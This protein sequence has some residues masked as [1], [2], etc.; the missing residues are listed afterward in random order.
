MDPLKQ[1]MAMKK[2]SILGGM[3]LM[4]AAILAMYACN[5]IDVQVDDEMADA[6]KT[7]P[8]TV[9]VGS[10][11]PTTRATVL[12]DYQT[13]YFA[14]GDKLY[15]T[16]TNIK[17]VLNIQTGA[18]TA[19]A[20]FSGD[21][22]YSGEGSPADNLELTATLVSAQQTEGKQVSV[23][24]GGVVTVNYPKES[25]YC[26]SVNDAVQQYSRLTGTSTYGA[27]SFTLTQHTAFLNF[28]I[29]FMD[30]TTAGTS[31]NTKVYFESLVNSYNVTTTKE[32]DNV[33]AK[34]VLPVAGGTKTNNISVDMRGGTY[35]FNIRRLPNMTLEGKVYNLKR[36]FYPLNLTNPAVGQIIC[37]D[38]KNYN[39]NTYHADSL[40]SKLP[41]VIPVARI[42][43]IGKNYGLA[44]AMKKE[45]VDW[46]T[47]MAKAAAH[48]PTFKRSY[49]TLASQNEWNEMFAIAGNSANLSNGLI[50]VGGP[51]LL[52][53][54]YSSTKNGADKVKFFISAGEQWGGLWQ[55]VYIKGSNM[56]VLPCLHFDL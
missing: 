23:N 43:K 40:A 45:Q 6:A 32:G 49:W 26:T 53:G 25:S 10:G 48:E 8:Y 41:G 1:K 3:T 46:N 4:M 38:G 51:N 29:T 34:F 14:E 52:G 20:T 22:T 44:L 35:K 17:G 39:Y 15:I 9:Q 7:I 18:G 33:V 21:L 19:S 27:K 5:S 50:S 47:A 2:N 16:G 12:D 30:G 36:T 54:C 55:D 42:C 13:L 28:A 37:N 56:F 31:L 11:D 24:A